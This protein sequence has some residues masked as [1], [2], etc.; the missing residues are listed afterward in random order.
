MAVKFAI[1]SNPCRNTYGLLRRNDVA[2]PNTPTDT[3]DAETD[4]GVPEED[5]ESDTDCPVC[6]HTLIPWGKR[7]QCECCDY[8]EILRNDYD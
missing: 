4:S 6:R 7:L 2:I 1:Q 3:L 8:Y 5:A